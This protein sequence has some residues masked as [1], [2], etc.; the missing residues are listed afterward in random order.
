MIIDAIFFAIIVVVAARSLGQLE[1]KAQATETLRQVSPRVKQALDIADQLYANKRYHSAEK[2]YLAV[3]KH[4]HK[5][6][7]A[8][9]HLGIIYSQL[10]NYPDAIECFQITTQ[11]VPSATTYHN[12]GLVYYEN[13]NYIKAIAAYQKSIM[14][15]PSPP[16]YIAL[17]KAYNKI[18]DTSK[19]IYSLEQALSLAP[20][21][22]RTLKL[23][24]DAYVQTKQ[25]AK[26]GQ[27]SQAILA[28][29][30]QDA[31]AA[32]YHAR[33]PKRPQAA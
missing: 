29:D 32:Q 24:L 11:L 8:Y 12:L 13:R 31:K 17:G 4:D 27:V 33:H 28:I 25:P 18:S 9:N 23:L 1:S 14:F 26:A 20:D 30:P 2:A 6:I 15:E 5:N 21:N 22:L 19:M 3:L 7:S 16:R 10:K